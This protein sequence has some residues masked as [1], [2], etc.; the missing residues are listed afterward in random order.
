MAR[1][2]DIKPGF[3]KNEFLAECDPMARL[4]FVGLWTIADRD[5]RIECRPLRIKA[6]LFPYDNV[7]IVAMLEQLRVRGF[8]RAYDAEGVRYIDIPGFGDNQRVHPKEQSEGH[9]AWTDGGNVDFHGE[10]CNATACRG[11]PRQATASRGKT[12]ASCALPSLPSLPSV[13]SLPSFEFTHTAGVHAGEEFRQPGWASVEWERFVAV[14]NATARAKPWTPLT[15]PAG[16]VDAAAAPGWADMARQAVERLP[17]CEFFKTPLAVTK[18]LEPGWVDRILAGEF[19]T[20]LPQRS[21]RPGPD[22]PM[23]LDEKIA[24]DRKESRTKPAWRAAPA[25]CPDDLAGRFFNKMLSQA[26]FEENLKQAKT[27]AATRRSSLPVATESQKRPT[28]PQKQ[29]AP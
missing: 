17:K 9:P 15:P 23:S 5:G 19:D 13:P 14:W 22:A 2:R 10:K 11:K 4:L 21:G 1:T 20:A 6:E 7:D 18:F 27:I 24:L 26:Q 28:T 3:F 29:T 25:G 8:V 12:A 16:W